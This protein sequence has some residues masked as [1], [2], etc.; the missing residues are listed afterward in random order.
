MQNI[1]K[2]RRELHAGAVNNFF[3]VLFFLFSERNY[4]EV[5]ASSII[6]ANNKLN[7]ASRTSVVCRRHYIFAVNLKKKMFLHDIY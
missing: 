3:P 1:Q 4:G 5:D 7:E 2:K 6:H